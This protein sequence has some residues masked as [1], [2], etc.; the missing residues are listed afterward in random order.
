MEQVHDHYLQS[1]SALRHEVS[2]RED[3]KKRAIEEYQN[4]KGKHYNNLN[5]LMYL[6]ATHNTHKLQ[7]VISQLSK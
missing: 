4:K 6:H 2:Q 1:M 7:F 3:D 5:S